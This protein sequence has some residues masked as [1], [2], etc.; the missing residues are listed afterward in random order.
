MRCQLDPNNQDHRNWYSSVQRGDLKDMSWAFNLEDGDDDWS[1]DVD[2]NGRSYVKRSIRNVSKLYDVTICATPAY[3]QT[4]V[5][6]RSAAVR[7]AN[8]FEQQ[9][10]ERTGIVYK[11]KP[12]V[13]LSEDAQLRARAAA[14][15]ED[16]RQG[17]I[18]DKS[19]RAVKLVNGKFY[20]D[21]AR[22]RQLKRYGS[23]GDGPG[24]GPV[25]TKDAY[26]GGQPADPTASL[27]CPAYSVS[28]TRDEHRAAVI[29][30]R[31]L[32]TRAKNPESAAWHY[33][34]ADA[35]QAAADNPSGENVVRAITECYKKAMLKA[36]MES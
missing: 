26:N 10:F 25:E 32:A 15:G 3:P 22:E 34:R 24:F 31:C 33:G 27:R 28:S 21:Y 8:S 36:E 12:V 17:D 13:M 11:Y 19:C 7:K 1:D 9:L 20:R 5:S 4:S 18:R 23:A 6:A 29:H 16:I 2:E 30:H 14:Y 35:H